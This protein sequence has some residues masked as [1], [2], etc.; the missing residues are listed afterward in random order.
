[1]SQ[2]RDEERKVFNALLNESGSER[3][4]RLAE[5]LHRRYHRLIY[6]FLRIFEIADEQHH[7]LFNQIF[8]K[9]MKGLERIKHCDN[10]K[11]WVVTITKNEIFSFLQQQER[12]V[13]LHTGED[14]SVTVLALVD[15]DVM[16]LFPPE[17]EIFG[18][19][20]RSAFQECIKKL[21]ED[22]RYPFLLRYREYMKWRE[23]G[24]LLRV[25]TDTA[26][27]RAERARRIVL[28]YLLRKFGREKLV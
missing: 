6:Y 24:S 5:E 1:M 22:I 20:L 3:F 17:K 18:K 4:P 8:L 12:E 19:Q 16:S 9:I 14:D 15:G 10:I 21:S 7:D 28:Q 13:R 11:S 2:W 25:N 23:I 27:K 26:R